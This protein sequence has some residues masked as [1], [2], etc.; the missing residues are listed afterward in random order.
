M[1]I[2]Y[3]LK[4]WRGKERETTATTSPKKTT[5]SSTCKDTSVTSCQPTDNRRQYG[6]GSTGVKLATG[7]KRVRPQAP[8]RNWATDG[9]PTLHACSLTTKGR[10]LKIGTWNVRGM[11]QQGK[12]EIIEKEMKN[13]H[14]DLLG[15]SESHLKNK[16]H[17]FTPAGY[18][19][20]NSGAQ[21]NSFSGVGFL[22]SKHLQDK[23]MGYN[24]VSG[25]GS[26]P[27]NQHNTSLC[28]NFR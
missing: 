24:T 27:S 28:S 15:I 2:K 13:Y 25:G 8:C 7:C 12:T 1:R 11:L 22:I 18:M 20:I 19:H 14:L 10:P 3:P 23:I 6:S 17:Y 5:M 16:G 21:D 4:A 26:P 9:Y